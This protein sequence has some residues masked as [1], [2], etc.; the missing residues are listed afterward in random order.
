M[1]IEDLVFV[2]PDTVTG[3]SAEFI[4]FLKTKTGLLKIR[5]HEKLTET[6]KCK[7]IPTN[8]RYDL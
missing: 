5:R 8:Y 6:A 2:F 7:G 1:K 3:P 4:R